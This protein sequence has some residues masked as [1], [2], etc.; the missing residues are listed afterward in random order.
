MISSKITTMESACTMG[1]K[2]ISL[3]PHSSLKENR[4][5]VYLSHLQI[6]QSIWTI[7]Y[8]T[9]NGQRLRQILKNMYMIQDKLNP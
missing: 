2:I 9:E 8:N 7:E 1:R 5:S 4:L 3:I 6:I